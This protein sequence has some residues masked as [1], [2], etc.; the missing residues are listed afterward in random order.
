MGFALAASLA[1]FILRPSWTY[2]GSLSPALLATTFLLALGGDSPGASLQVWRATGRLIGCPSWPL[3]VPWG[4][5]RWSCFRFSLRRAPSVSLLDLARLHGPH[6]SARLS[7]WFEPPSAWGLR[8]RV[9]GTARRGLGSR[10]PSTV[11]RR[12]PQGSLSSGGGSGQTS[13]WWCRTGAR[14][15]T[16]LPSSVLTG[17]SVR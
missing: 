15:G 8:G 10:S 4:F 1:G 3:G 5:V 6:N 14:N 7:K 12:F 13:R 16:V 9:V 17:G 2:C 11:A